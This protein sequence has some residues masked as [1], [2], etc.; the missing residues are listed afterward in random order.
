MSAA[1][2]LMLAVRLFPMESTR[3]HGEVNRK[4]GN[5]DLMNHSVYGFSFMV[6][7]LQNSVFSGLLIAGKRSC[8]DGVLMICYSEKHLHKDILQIGQIF[9][10]RPLVF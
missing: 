8:F 7:S 3:N 4:M 10:H 6:G 5:I 9:L 2:F 1:I